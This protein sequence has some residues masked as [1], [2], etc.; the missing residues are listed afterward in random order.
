MTQILTMQDYRN[1]P[2]KNGQ[3]STLEVARSHGEGLEDFDWRVSIADVKTAGPFSHFMNRQRII[4]VLEGN[5]L[6]LHVDDKAPVTLPPKAF[7]AFHGESRVQAELVNGAIRDFN[8]IYNPEKYRARLQWVN[9]SSLNAWISDANEILVFNVASNL[10][11]E[12]N[13]TLFNLNSFETLLIKDNKKVLQ[14]V[15]SPQD[16]VNFCIIELFVR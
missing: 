16:E 8:L 11:I 15:T 6:I 1:M 3:G 2:W 5:G 7:F 10:G 9:S 12:V 14:W 4:G 13:S